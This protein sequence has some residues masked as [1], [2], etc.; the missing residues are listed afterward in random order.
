MGYAATAGSGLTLNL[1]AGRN[2]CSNTMTNY[3]GGTLTMANNTT[4]YVYLDTSSS[5]APASNTS[6][7]ASTGIALDTVVTSGGVITTITDDRVFGLATATT[8]SG[9]VNH[10]LSFTI[11]SPI[12]GSTDY[13]ADVPFPCTISRYGILV[14]TGTITVKFWKIASGTA[15]PT[16]SNSINTSGVGVSSGTVNQSTTLTDF[17]TTSVAAHDI[18]AMN[19]TAV[20][21]PTVV[22][23][24]LQCNQ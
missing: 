12:I 18:M 23:G 17:T 24:V 3:A 14:D 20:S 10:G 9:T 7:Y 19:V 15:I 5:C 16:S 13:L 6:G 2:R 11:P 1:A 8:S 22:N 21:G 4:N